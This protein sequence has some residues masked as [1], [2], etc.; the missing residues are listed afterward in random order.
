MSPRRWSLRCAALLSG[1]VL[2][3]HELRYAVAYRGHAHAALAQQG[4]AYLALVTPFAVGLAVL[5]LAAFVRTLARG[6]ATRT[7]SPSASVTRLWAA[8]TIALMVIHFGQER[9]EGLLAPGHPGGL[10][11]TFG[12]GGLVAVALCA[13]IGGLVALALRGADATR[14]LAVAGHAV[15]ARFARVGVLGGART[16]A[17]PTLELLAPALGARAPPCAFV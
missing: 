3:V 8:A 15:R 4:H 1:G 10:A 6:P 7:G 5:A 12:H 16:P 13:A 17:R 2:A 9:I 14:D 11:G